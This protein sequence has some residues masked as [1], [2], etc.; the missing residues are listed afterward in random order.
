MS[1]RAT[2]DSDPLQHSLGGAPL[3]ELLVT[4]HT[5]QDHLLKCAPKA[6]AQVAI[7]PASFTLASDGGMRSFGALA[8]KVYADSFLLR[9]LPFQAPVPQAGNAAPRFP[10]SWQPACA[11]SLANSF[12]PFQSSEHEQ[13]FA[14]FS[15]AQ[16]FR[17]QQPPVQES[18]HPLMA[19]PFTVAG[20]S[21]GR[22]FNRFTFP[23]SG[24][25]FMSMHRTFH[26]RANFITQT[27]FARFKFER[28][29]PFGWTAFEC[30]HPAFFEDL[31]A[32][33]ARI[34]LDKEAP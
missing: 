5:V 16:P 8:N 31:I 26:P 23:F 27:P 14:L 19:M 34:E 28:Y 18:A 29:V 33:G 6:R 12:L 11:S 20:T 1:G 13:R 4:A 22:A 32:L 3:P 25:T 2:P 9:P 21:S 15:T 24:A 7:S 30:L 17:T 10:R